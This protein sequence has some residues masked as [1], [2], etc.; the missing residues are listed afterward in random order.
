M[1]DLVKNFKIELKRGITTLLV[2]HHLQRKTYGYL[3]LQDLSTY[4]IPI[5]AG[6]LYPL[7][8][9]LES[10]GILDSDWDTSQSR[11]RK[12]Y[13]LND[14]GRYIYNQLLIEWREMERTIKMIL[15]E[16]NDD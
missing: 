8:R 6:T 11:A 13:C 7:L 1:E 5:E 2:L 16:E 15:M 3:L 10:Q 12:Y 14:N 9:R 4:D